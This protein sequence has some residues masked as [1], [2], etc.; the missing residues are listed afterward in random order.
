M[1]SKQPK[2]MQTPFAQQQAQQQQQTN[3]YAPFSIAGTPEAQAFLS[4][5]LDFGAETNVDP[6]VGRRTDLAEQEVENRYNSAFGG[7]VPSFIREMNRARELRGVRSQGAAEARE[8]EYVNQQANN[9]RRQAMT[10]AELE[11]RRLLLPQILQT[12]G[13]STG[14]GSTSGYGTQIVQPQQG[15]WHKAGLG[16]I[17]GAADTA[18]LIATGGMG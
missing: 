1:P 18:R 10:M 7:G 6:G 12:G 15:F 3:T 14:S 13:S 2:P 5:P 11:R 9:Q 17:S 4:A 16:L 8:A